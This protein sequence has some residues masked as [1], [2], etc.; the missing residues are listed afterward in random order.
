MNG[1]KVNCDRATKE[2]NGLLYEPVNT[3]ATD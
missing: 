2:R 1:S 3:Q